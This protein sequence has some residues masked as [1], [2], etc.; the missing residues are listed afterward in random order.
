ME[1]IEKLSYDFVY[2]GWKEMEKSEEIDDK[3]SK[4]VYPYWTLAYMIRP[5][6]ARIL[7]N[8]VI[9]CNIIPVDEYLPTK[10]SELKVAGYKENVVEPVSREDGGSDVLATSRYDYFLD[11]NIHAV[12]VA[13]DKTKALKLFESA[14]THN[15][16]IINLGKN[17]TWEGGVMEAG[18]GGGQKINLVKEYIAD[19]KDLSLI[20]ISEPTRPY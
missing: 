7:V 13:T 5:E 20:H 8:D 19:K 18:K 10:M 16:T 1:E 15:S 17:I 12:T 6:A 11:F 4:P 9:K 3:L 14:N 2:L